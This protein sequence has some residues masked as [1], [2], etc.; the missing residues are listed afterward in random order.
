MH[1]AENIHHTRQFGSF[2][3]D[4]IPEAKAFDLGA[5]PKSDDQS[6]AGT[7]YWVQ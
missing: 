5:S 2:C 3:L 6:D 1:Q 4:A 7:F